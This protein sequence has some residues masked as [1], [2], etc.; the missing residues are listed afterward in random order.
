MSHTSKKTPYRRPRSGK[1]SVL[2]A[3]R[4]AHKIA[5][6]PMMFQAVRSLISFGI[7]PYLRQAG[8]A[9]LADIQKQ[10]GLSAYAAGLLMDL[11]VYGDIALEQNGSF[12]LTKLGNYLADDAAVRV[13]MNFMNDVCYQ[14]AFK[15]DESLKT[16]KPVGLP[17]FGDYETIYQGLSRLPAGVKKSWFEFDN[18]YSDLIFDA[19]VDIVLKNHPKTVYDIGGNTAKFEVSLLQKDAAVAAHIFDLPGQLEKARATLEKNNLSARVQL[20][21]M[22]V[23]DLAASFPKSPDAV[24]MSQF[25][26]CFSPEKILDILTKVRE[27]LSDTS[28]VYILEPFVDLQNPVAALALTNISF[29]FT[30]M[31]N[32][33]SK[34]YKQ[35]EMLA[36]IERAG[37][38]LIAA[39]Q[40]LGEYDYTLLECKRA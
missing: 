30:C 11:A 10:S 19:A 40:R 13:N 1:M 21:A 38:K 12:S 17:V 26:D 4:E 33:Y 32:G 37:L 2:D 25:L 34:F 24:W 31:A 23:L 15:L 6:Y 14:G 18:Y 16:G 20:H 5:F 28:R 3:Q 8:K 9:S 27:S 7:L 35:H 22:N 39:H 29:Y 36:L